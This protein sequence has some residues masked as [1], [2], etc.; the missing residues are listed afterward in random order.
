M[1]CQ[2]DTCVSTDGANGQP[3]YLS[4]V[5]A[6][7]PDEGRRTQ[8]PKRYDNKNKDEDNSPRVNNDNSS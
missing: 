1:F 7:T 4:M 3:P 5:S 6:H 8:R 2:L